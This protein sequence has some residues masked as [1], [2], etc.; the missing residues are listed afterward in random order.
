MP[1]SPSGAPE[2]VSLESLDAEKR[3]KVRTLEGGVNEL[4][5]VRPEF[6]AFLQHYGS[7]I[8]PG[9]VLASREVSLDGGTT[10]EPRLRESPILTLVRHQQEGRDLAECVDW[11]RVHAHVQS[12][13]S[14]ASDSALAYE[15]FRDEV[16]VECERVCATFAQAEAAAN[17]TDPDAWDAWKGSELE[18]FFRMRTRESIAAH[19]QLTD[20]DAKIER[21]SQKLLLRINDRTPARNHADIVRRQEAERDR[22]LRERAAFVTGSPEAFLE[23]HTQRLSSMKEVFDDGGTIVETPYVRVRMAQIQRTLEQHLPVFVHGELGSGKTELAKHLSR[24]NLSAQHVARWEQ[25]HPRPK[26]PDMLKKWKEDRADQREALVVYGHRA[27]E[28]EQMLASR[29]IRPKDVPEPAEYLARLGESW[30]QYRD[31]HVLRLDEMI[32][33]ETSAAKR[34]ALEDERGAI[35]SDGRKSFEEAFKTH[36][37]GGIKT[38]AIFGPILQAMKQ[39][40]PVI[41][42]E[43]NAIPHRTLIV[44]NSL[45]TMKPGQVVYP[46]FPDMEPFP[47]QSG[48]NVI[49]TGNYKPEDGENYR[50]RMML[51]AAYLSRFG[52][53]VHYD[54]LPMAIDA[55]PEGLSAEELRERRSGNEL[56]QMLV[57]R[58]LEED[59]SLRLPEKG[60]DQ[61]ERLARVA[62]IIQNVFSGRQEEGLAGVDGSG[63]EIELTKVIKENVL[64]IR[65]LLPIVDQWKREGFSRPLDD[66]LYERYVSRSS[67]A[68]PLEKVNLYRLLRTQA[69]FFADEQRWPPLDDGGKIERADKTRS[70]HDPEAWRLERE[71]TGYRAPAIAVMSAR[72]VVERLFGPLPAR[73]EVDRAIVDPS[74]RANAGESASQMPKELL[75]RRMRMMAGITENV[76]KVRGEDPDALAHAPGPSKKK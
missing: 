45:L 64:S 38:E 19:K 43:M 41:I 62:R 66:Y 70:M 6:R 10:Q 25:E 37:E 52:A 20:F 47:V 58:L 7:F 13:V 76:G 51:D 44:L 15:D 12:I 63:N 39:G 29:G 11:E 28:V 18:R 14:P 16:L 5:S 23:E 30:R 74:A 50:D 1:S 17:N 57:T 59:L 75:A 54:Y 60:L 48:F 53:I 2:R 71:R 69:D 46:P 73:T 24:R 4:L 61:I 35:D 72:D 27:L 55:E 22:L 31:A 40:R 67:H 26:D 49:A 56:L 42:D 3:R 36:A 32:S 68:R 8:V 33:A 21:V 65:H 9:K 34:R